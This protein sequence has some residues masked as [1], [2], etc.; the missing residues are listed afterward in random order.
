MK[1]LGKIFEENW[2]KSVPDYI[3]YYRFRDSGNTFYG[4]NQGLRFTPSNIADCLI[5]D[6]FTGLHLIELKNHKG[7][8]IPLSCILGTR[9]NNKPTTKEK[10]MQD[11][12][13]AN[14]YTGVFSHI[15]VFFSD[16]ERCF[17]LGINSFMKFI[18]DVERKSIPIEYFEKYGCEIEVEKLRTNYRFNIEKWLKEF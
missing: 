1:N 8:S 7:K 13:E 9:K 17:E 5:Q 15:I 16:E 18:N 2:R 11:L 12:C 10:Q 3:Y 14:K 6:P 4:G